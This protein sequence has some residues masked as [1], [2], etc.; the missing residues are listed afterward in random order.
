MAFQAF[1]RDPSSA[2]ARTRARAR[3]SSPRPAIIMVHMGAGLTTTQGF[4]GANCEGCMRVLRDCRR[5]LQAANKFG[6]LLLSDLLAGPGARAHQAPKLAPFLR[7]AGLGPPAGRHLPRFT[8]RRAGGEGAPAS[9]GPFLWS[10]AHSKKPKTR[11]VELAAPSGSVGRPVEYPQKP[12]LFDRQVELQ[13]R[14]TPFTTFQSGLQTSARAFPTMSD[15]LADVRR[16]ACR[17][18]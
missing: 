13:T 17:L 9:A 6:G 18:A 4:E 12:G 8:S 14:E 15:R 16:V 7:P 3:D 2:P 5:R 11:S 10:A 1:G